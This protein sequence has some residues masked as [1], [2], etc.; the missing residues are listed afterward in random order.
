[1]QR[2]HDESSILDFVADGD[3]PEKYRVIFVGRSLIPGVHG[4]VQIGHT[5]ELELRLGAE[6]PRVPPQVNWKTPIVHPNIR[7]EYFCAG[8]LSGLWSPVIKLSDFVEVLWDFARLAIF[9][10]HG[11]ENYWGEIDRRFGLPIDKRPL[12]DKVYRPD[13][14]SSIM[15]PEPQDRNDLVFLDDDPENC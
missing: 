11:S 9:T 4:D 15:R 6:Y 7:G 10:A 3:P 14:G 5:Q 2:L 12:R 8:N 13:T 1:M